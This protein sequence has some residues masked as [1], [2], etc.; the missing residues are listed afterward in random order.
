MVS[1]AMLGFTSSAPTRSSGYAC[2][3]GSSSKLGSRGGW[4]KASTF[5]SA[6][7]RSVSGEM[8]GFISFSP[9]ELSVLSKYFT[10]PPLNPPAALPPVSPQKLNT[11]L[12]N[13]N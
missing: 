8:L 10:N 13:G 3:I 12:L 9:T 7:K 6:A 2:Y 1:G 11:M 5:E 4:Q